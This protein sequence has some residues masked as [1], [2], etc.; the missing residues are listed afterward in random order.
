M[1]FL[2]LFWYPNNILVY[3]SIQLLLI[4]LLLIFTTICCLEPRSFLVM[5]VNRYIMVLWCLKD[6]HKFAFINLLISLFHHL[7]EIRASA[8]EMDYASG[9]KTFA[10]CEYPCE[11]YLLICFWTIHW[12]TLIT[13]YLRKC[14]SVE[15]KSIFDY[16][17]LTY[18]GLMIIRLSEI[19]ELSFIR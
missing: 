10:D 9:W 2:K 19:L 12:L 18:F 8:T 14:D 3:L 17:R 16:V 15:W 7:F 13:E 5:E 1:Y 11:I 4:W 6:Y